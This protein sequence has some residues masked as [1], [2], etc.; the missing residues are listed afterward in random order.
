MHHNE[1]I[2]T[3]KR[4]ELPSAPAPESEAG[5]RRLLVENQ[6]LL[7]SLDTIESL[8]VNLQRHATPEQL[9]VDFL[10]TFLAQIGDLFPVVLSGVYRVDPQS[11]AFTLERCL[12]AGLREDLQQEAQQQIAQGAF[13]LAL[14]RSR[15]T[16]SASISLH[17]YHPRVRTLILVPL[18]T[19]Q[20]VH[21][22]AV[23][24][25]ERVEQDIALYEL[26]LLS[27]LAGQTALALESTQREAALQQQK[28][29]LEET[30][31]Q[32]TAELEQTNRTVLQ[33]N[34]ELEAELKKALE[35]NERLSTVDR[36]RESLLATVSHELRT[37]LSAILG[38]LDI[39]HQEWGHVL[40]PEG[41]KLLEICQRN[42]IM[43][44]SLVS[45]LLDVAALRH[46]QMVL[47]PRVIPL[48][49]VVQRTFVALAPMARANGVK[50]L[51]AVLPHV[52]VYA[53]EQRLQ[54]IFLNLIGNAI[55]FSRKDDP[56]VLVSATQ[57]DTQV[58]I[59]VSDNG[60]G[61][62]PE[63]IG[64]IFEPFV[65]GTESYT[66]PTTG[67]GLGLTICKALVERHGGSIWV[68]SEVG[69]GSRFF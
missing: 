56:Q 21:G 58:V 25:T 29:A 52:E 37:P 28:A 39:I 26:K 41:Q 4:A 17:R 54:Q 66:A 63:K 3:T 30:V 12:P 19:V 69:K 38:S 11:H 31:Q 50:L 18:V 35:V 53:D 36:M 16:V 33:L 47:H 67:A 44:L 40:P 64:R 34:K 9:P 61:I 65:Q 45:D 42:G 8:W 22:M 14:R 48:S 68:E 15:P 13:A 32:R 5:L 20:E 43:L 24:A 59:S 60:I 6:R 7:D 55:K 46:K 57:E 23:I 1:N 10:A 27:L 51:N 2:T 62:P 49:P